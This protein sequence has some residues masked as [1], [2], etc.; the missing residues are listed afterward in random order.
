MV[1]RNGPIGVLALKVATLAPN[2]VED[3]V[4]IRLQN[5]EDVFALDEMWTLNIA[6]IYLRVQP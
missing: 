6:T 5:L 2:N 4:A 1:G 3:R